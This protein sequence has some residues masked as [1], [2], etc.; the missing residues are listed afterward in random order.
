M[1]QAL[2]D[3]FKNYDYDVFLKNSNV[4]LDLRELRAALNNPRGRIRQHHLDE[5]LKCAVSMGDDGACLL[6]LR[7]GANAN[8]TWQFQA[9]YETWGDLD[10]APAL[11]HA[12]AGGRVGV[13]ETLL[14][15]L[16]L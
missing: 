14:V 15:C 11:L 4:I 13:V 6:L 3:L 2:L 8:H 1:S 7:A 9:P 12:V 16:A 10:S 5:A